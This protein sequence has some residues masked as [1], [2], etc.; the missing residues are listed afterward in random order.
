MTEEK[1]EK[2]KIENIIWISKKKQKKVLVV[3]SWFK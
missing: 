3:K 2:K 1:Y